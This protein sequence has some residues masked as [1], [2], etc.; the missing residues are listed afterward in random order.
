MKKKEIMTND[1][2]VFKELTEK[3]KNPSI[4]TEHIYEP[5]TGKKIKI[6]TIETRTKIYRLITP[7]D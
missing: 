6:Q 7:E 4:L 2:S 5:Y 3:V 1:K